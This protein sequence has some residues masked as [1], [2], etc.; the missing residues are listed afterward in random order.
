V[1][2]QALAT[3]NLLANV[4]LVLDA[5]AMAGRLGYRSGIRPNHRMPARNYHF[6]GQLEFQDREWLRPGERCE[7]RGSFIVAEQD[8]GNFIPGFT[9]EVCEGPTKV[10]GT[11]TLLSIEKWDSK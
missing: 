2:D 4:E 5:K 8:R 11:C 10:V 9:W 3:I 6:I 1:S 7:A